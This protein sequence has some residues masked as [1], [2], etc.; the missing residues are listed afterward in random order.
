MQD[1]LVCVAM[2]TYNGERFL[3]EQLD[4]ILNQTYTNLE[5][6]IC[7]DMSSDKTIEII[8]SYQEADS[9]IKLFQN[10]KNLGYLK[11]FEKA[12]SLC[13]GDFIALSDQDDIWKKEKIQTFLNEIKDN[14]LIYSDA[15]I[16]D[17]NSKEDA[18]H[19]V[20]PKRCLISGAC[21]KSLLVENCIS[22]NTMMFKKELV[23]QILPIPQKISYHDIWIAFVAST[24]STI[25]YATKPMTYY[26]RYAEQITHHHKVQSKHIFD[27]I[28]N[29]E[30]IKVKENSV[31]LTNLEVF[32]TLEILKDKETINIINLL[33]EHY[34]NYKKIFFS[35]NLYAILKRNDDEVFAIFRPSKRKRKAFRT[36]VGLKLQKLTLFKL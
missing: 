29:K 15:I 30:L 3:K 6:I 25:T 26:R 2:C 18:K 20:E 8:R 11:N 21:N 27:K 24:C 33:I 1:N 19:L 13:N 7:D 10:E 14:I 34:I 22:G 28:H 4:S 23:S 12:I 36:S 17:E 31:I 32:K 16:I 35:F 5:I 9:R